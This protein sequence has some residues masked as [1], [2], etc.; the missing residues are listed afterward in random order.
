MNSTESSQPS[1]RMQSRNDGPNSNDGAGGA[2]PSMSDLM[3]LG[4]SGMGMTSETWGQV[5]A[6]AAMLAAQLR[7]LESQGNV[8]RPFEDNHPQRQQQ[9][10][11]NP[12]MWLQQNI[13]QGFPS[14]EM[15]GM[16][17]LFGQRGNMVPDYRRMQL[18]HPGPPFPMPGNPGNPVV[19]LGPQAFMRNLHG[20]GGVSPG[21]N[22]AMDDPRRMKGNGMAAETRRHNDKEKKR[23]KRER[24][25]ELVRSVRFL[26]SST[27]SAYPWLGAAAS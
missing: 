12:A 9:D 5:A 18:P 19:P 14:Q 25:G 10:Q 7:E 2:M 24:I 21:N 15:G 3:N 16:S 17:S 13:M 1:M 4:R 11:H 20:M 8:G 23:R 6:R 22:G 26:P 27:R